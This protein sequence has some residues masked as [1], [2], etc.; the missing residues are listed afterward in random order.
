LNLKGYFLIGPEDHFSS[1]ILP[2]N[3]GEELEK[4]AFNTISALTG[5]TEQEHEGVTEP[6][7]AKLKKA[8]RPVEIYDYEKNG[9]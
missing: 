8:T 9:L 3:A 1:S 5:L 6:R 2:V 4:E 7:K